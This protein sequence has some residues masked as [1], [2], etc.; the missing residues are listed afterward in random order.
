MVVNVVAVIVTR[1]PGP[2]FEDALASLATQDHPNLSILVLDDGSVEAVT[3]RVAAVVPSAFV[4]R[5]DRAI[6]FSAAA[7]QVLEM[8]QGAEYYLFCHDDVALAPDAVRLLV[9]EAETGG[10]DLLGPKLVTWNDHERLVS[11][12]LSVDRA[13]STIA[14]VEP[15]ELD[16]GQHD[17]VREVA[18][19]PGAVLLARASSFAALDGFDETLTAPSRPSRADRADRAQ[20]AERSGRGARA[21]AADRALPADAGAASEA[22]VPAS[23]TRTVESGPDVGEDIDLSWR[24]RQQRMRLGVA[25]AA[26][27]AHAGEWHGLVAGSSSSERGEADARD[28]ARAI[29]QRTRE[30]NRMRSM[31]TTASGVRVPF[32]VPLLALQSIWRARHRSRAIGGSP[33]GWAAWRSVFQ[34]LGA[35]RGQRRRVQQRRSVGERELLRPLTPVASRAGAALRA[36]VTADGARAWNVAERTVANDS[37]PARIV[38]LAAFVGALVLLIGSRRIVFGRLPSVGQFAPLPSLGTLWRVT[39]S[40]WRDVGV[41]LTAPAPPAMWLLS[42]LGSVFL[43]ATGLL[44]T[45]LSVGMLP[46]GLV[47][48]WHLAGAAS[49]AGSPN[50]ATGTASSTNASANAPATAARVAQV[51]ATFAYA[52]VPLGYDAIGSGRLDGCIA[53]GLAPWIVRGLLRAFDDGT[54]GD[55]RAA[56]R[57]TAT[58]AADRGGPASIDGS[59]RLVTNAR[60]ERRATDRRNAEAD[61]VGRPTPR[62]KRSLAV[63]ALRFGV[64]LAAASALAPGLLI[65]ILLAGLGLL[66]GTLLLGERRAARALTVRLA[67]GYVAALVLLA[68]WSADLLRSGTHAAILTGGDQAVTLRASV[69]DLLRLNTGPVGAT[70]LGW[71]LLVAAAFPLFV[72]DGARFRG[73]VRAW[74]LILV[75]VAGV[76]MAGRGWLGLGMANPSVALVPAGVGIALAAGLGIAGFVADARNRRFGWRQVFAIA[77]LLT[78]AAGA[79]PVVAASLGGRWNLPERD[80]DKALGWMPDQAASGPFRT[81]WIG[82]PSV[83]PAA[84]WRVGPDLAFATTENGLPDVTDQWGSRRTVGIDAIAA[85]LDLV[86]SGRTNRHGAQLADWGVRYIVLV[87][88]AAPRA[89]VHP[90]SVDVRR[91]FD[92][93]LDLRQIESEAGLTVYENT[94]WSPVRFVV[95][96]LADTGLRNGIVSPTDLLRSQAAFVGPRNTRSFATEVAPDSAVVFRSSFDSAW[97]LTVGGRSIAPIPLET[98]GMVFVP[99]PTDEAAPSSAIDEEPVAASGSAAVLAYDDGTVH[100]LVVTLQVLLWMAAV[101]VLVVARASRHQSREARLVA[102]ERLEAAFEPDSE[103]DDRFGDPFRTSFAPAGPQAFGIDA[104]F[105]LAPDTDDGFGVFD[106]PVRVAERAARRSPRPSRAPRGTAARATSVS[107]DVPGEGSRAGSTPGSTAGSGPSP[108]AG[109]GS[110]ATVG[111]RAAAD[112][113][114]LPEDGSL[115]DELWAQW[116]RRR[117]VEST[118]DDDDA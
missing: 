75:S 11:V 31:L 54:S 63:D 108:V 18:S 51:T 57:R 98:G 115:A 76:W 37:V 95:P 66:L 4:R 56:D 79:V 10:F 34:G 1:N 117:G 68:P 16:Q 43:G 7:N 53:I 65:G 104:D 86:T 99:P 62:R 33:A 13:G 94:A 40:G 97:R 19:L 116:S 46:I 14:L 27:A 29:V 102:Q 15:F 100:W 110:S 111:E 55:E 112:G 39:L 80:I 20:R 28:R 26:R 49:R 91:G 6:G 45:V 88:R 5:H 69:L 118:R 44:Q 25:P 42:I 101:G 35:T 105:D 58:A 81:L 12:G 83:L 72:A 61:A 73:A 47:G 59:P 77:S 48:M 8:V 107:R 52:V 103:T 41:G 64:P 87:T 23:R 106:T 78:I 30:R 113:S 71:F 89:P 50:D 3:A 67:L 85:D 60:F 17:A 38:A 36:D 22:D 93:Q 9:A 90:L 74:G 70:P 96:V 24:A 2:W 84:S 21:K 114:G 109:P 92:D 82:S 32:I